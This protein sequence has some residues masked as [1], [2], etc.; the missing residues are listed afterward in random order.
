MSRAGYAM[1]EVLNKLLQ[2]VLSQ[3]SLP[4]AARGPMTI[5]LAEADK[6]M[7]DG[8]DEELLLQRVLTGLHHAVHS[9]KTAAAKD[10]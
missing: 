8:A 2:E 1:S 10:E 6:R 3:T 7:A 9:D 4:D 5:L